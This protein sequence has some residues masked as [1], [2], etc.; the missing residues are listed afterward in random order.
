MADLYG[1]T[2]NQAPLEAGS[3]A[4]QQTVV[5][6]ARR[7]L[8]PQYAQ[9]VRQARQSSANRGLYNSPVGMLGENQ[10]QQDFRNKLFD[11]TQHAATGAADQALQDR[12]TA[13][14]RAFALQQQQ[15]AYGQ[16]D[17]QTNAAQEAANNQMWADLIGGAAGAVGTVYG[18][19]AGGMAAKAGADQLT[20]GMRKPAQQSNPYGTSLGVNTDLVS[21]LGY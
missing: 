21:Q 10:V 18:G 11:V 17:K 16:Q 1:N 13:L 6:N 8:A 2:S 20:Q 12:R 15:M 14:A 4:Y 5:N 9:A 7:Q 3:D 19:P